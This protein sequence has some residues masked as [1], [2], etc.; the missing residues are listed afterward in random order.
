M[1]TGGT[2][3]TYYGYCGI[4]AQAIADAAEITVESYPAGS[5]K[6][7]DITPFT[8]PTGYTIGYRASKTNILGGGYM[9][10]DYKIGG[11]Y[12]ENLESTS[13]KDAGLGGVDVH[14]QGV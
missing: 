4:I 11:A 1:A 14:V 7:F 5:Q 9:V 6:E 13:S 12:Y 8:V 2:S 3:G 10:Q